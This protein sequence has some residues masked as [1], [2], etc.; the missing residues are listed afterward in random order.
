MTAILPQQVLGRGCHFPAVITVGM[1]TA[2]GPAAD[3]RYSA[4]ITAGLPTQYS[5]A[6]V[7]NAMPYGRPTDDVIVVY[8]KV[9]DECMIYIPPTGAPRLT[10]YT[11]KIRFNDCAA[12]APHVP[13][14]FVAVLAGDPPHGG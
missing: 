7:D 11:E 14:T 1:A 4:R 12:P 2:E 9:D 3:A 6:G 5:G 8:A 10:V 13:G